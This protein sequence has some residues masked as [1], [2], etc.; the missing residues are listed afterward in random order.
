MHKTITI[1]I[2]W[3]SYIVHQ[4][5]MW[6]LQWVCVLGEFT[7]PETSSA[8]EHVININR[9]EDVS[10]HVNPLCI[11]HLNFHSST[12]MVNI[13]ISP[14]LLK[15]PLLIFSL[16]IYCRMR[17]QSRTLGKMFSKA[18][19]SVDVHHPLAD[20]ISSDINSPD[21]YFT[22]FYSLPLMVNIY[23]LDLSHLFLLMPITIFFYLSSYCW[24]HGHSNTLG[25]TFSKA[26]LSVD[27]R[28][29]LA[30]YISGHVN[31]LGISYLISQLIYDGEHL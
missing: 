17:K 28:H 11:S 18:K 3:L 25:N 2:S 9:A 5:V 8:R 14:I 29:P 26:K 30:D 23:F 24:M 6:L 4:Q 13:Y 31:S 27:V 7:R 21:N 12:M 16:F 22:Y 10:G 20:D 19:L 1:I 15:C